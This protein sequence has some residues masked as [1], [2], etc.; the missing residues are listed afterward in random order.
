MPVRKNIGFSKTIQMYMDG[1]FA[2]GSIRKLGISPSFAAS[3]AASAAAK[4]TNKGQREQF[5]SSTP[6][7]ASGTLR[8]GD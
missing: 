1:T 6:R 5:V 3:A 8:T 2:V 4:E 7:A